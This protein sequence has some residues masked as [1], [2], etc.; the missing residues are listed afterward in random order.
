MHRPVRV[1]RMQHFRVRD[2]A[3]Q[4]KRRQDKEPGQHNRREQFAHQPCTVLLDHEQQRQDNNGQRNH[5]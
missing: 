4:A 2:N 5:P 1:Q 3:A